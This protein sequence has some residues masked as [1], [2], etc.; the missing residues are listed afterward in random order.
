MLEKIK[1]FLSIFRKVFN[2]LEDVLALLV[3]VIVDFIFNFVFFSF[4]SVDDLTRFGFSAV[5]FLIVFYKVRSLMKNH[6]LLWF[7]FALITFYG[8]LNFSLIDIAYQSDHPNWRTERREAIKTDDEMLSLITDV[9]EKKATEEDLGKQYHE[10]TRRETMDQL[11]V[12]WS[13]STNERIKAEEKR[14]KY[15]DWF[16]SDN[17]VKI[18]ASDALRALFEAMKKGLWDQILFFGAIF[19]SIEAAI[20]F[21]IK[22][23]MSSKKKP[24]VIEEEK[25]ETELEPAKKE[26]FITI[27]KP[28]KYTRKEKKA[29]DVEVGDAF[30]GL[31]EEENSSQWD[32]QPSEPWPQ[33][34]AQKGEIPTLEL[35]IE[36]EQVKVTPAS[37]Q[38]KEGNPEN[39]EIVIDDFP[40]GEAHKQFA[41]KIKVG[42]EKFS[43]FIHALFNNEGKSSLRDKMEAAAVAGLTVIEAIKAFD[44]LAVTKFE[45][46]PLIEFRK[47][48]STWHS[49]F[50]PEWII[51]HTVDFTFY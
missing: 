38:P 12:K 14:D 18:K 26:E 32:I 20:F 27:R 39:Y 7:I 35:N 16:L 45:G 31:A 49:N 43:K 23:M 1:L 25:I 40:L 21:V 19:F 9:A 8:G 41:E 3:A 51:T 47:E 24:L 46:K 28:R 48:S 42:D 4:V 50:T 44:F 11:S 2:S 30:S 6:K 36:D 15:H 17:S 34:E 33:P 29:P 22:D 10:A 5:V 37:L 13:S